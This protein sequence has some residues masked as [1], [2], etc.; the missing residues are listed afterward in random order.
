M[1][2]ASRS[3]RRWQLFAGPQHPYTIGLLGAIPALARKR[4]RLASDRGHGAR[5]AA[6]AARLPLRAALPLRRGSRAAPTSRLARAVAPSHAR[7]AGARRTAGGRG[8]TAPLLEARDLVK[9]FPV[10]EGCSGRASAR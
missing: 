7:P 3:A 6:P 2:A 5:P 4:A 9:H 8:M 1:R 10:R